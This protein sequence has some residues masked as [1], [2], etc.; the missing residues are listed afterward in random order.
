[1]AVTAIRYSLDHPLGTGRYMPEMS[2][3]PAGLDTQMIEHI[4]T[5]T[6][7]NQF[8][9]VLVYYGFPGLALLVIFYLLTMRSL[10]RAAGPILR[11][12]DAKSLVLTVGVMGALAAYGV[13]SL[14]HNSGPF[15][16]DWYHFYLVGLVFS[17]QRIAASGR[18]PRKPDG[19]DRFLELHWLRGLERFRA[20]TS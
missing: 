20:R 4:L 11:S 14:F 5:S 2:H 12:R 3:L 15:V 7:H 1:M 18:E 6:P 16:G 8:L 19:V 17:L 9:V 13:N 10:L